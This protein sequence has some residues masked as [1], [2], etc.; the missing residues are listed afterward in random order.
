[1]ILYNH[2]PWYKSI[3]GA[4]PDVKLLAELEAEQLAFEILQR[5][6]QLIDD[7]SRI[8]ARKMKLAHIHEWLL[9]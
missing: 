9:R 6:L 3:F 5:E 2:I 4:K 8:D 1:M 7:R